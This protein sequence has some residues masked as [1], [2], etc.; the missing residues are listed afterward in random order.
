M[1]IR[2]LLIAVVVSLLLWW[3]VWRLCREIYV[4]G[5]LHGRYVAERSLAAELRTCRDRL[6]TLSPL[7]GR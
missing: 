7:A 3:A 5:E 6:S 2:Y 1:K 4:L